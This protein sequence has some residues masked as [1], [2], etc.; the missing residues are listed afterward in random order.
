MSA[1]SIC[2]RS[3]QANVSRQTYVALG[4]NKGERTEY[5]NEAITHVQDLGV[6]RT[7]GIQLHGNGTGGYAG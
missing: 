5:L 1:K 3:D 7:R 4:S 2:T 6:K